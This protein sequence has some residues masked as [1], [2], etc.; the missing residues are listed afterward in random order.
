MKSPT[1]PEAPST[2]PLGI[3]NGLPLPDQL[4][5]SII[6]SEKPT[7]FGGYSDIYEGLW[8]ISGAEVPVAIKVLRNVRIMN[9]IDGLRPKEIVARVCIS[10]IY[11]ARN[12]I[13]V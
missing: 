13:F 3:R 12:P 11:T 1:L 7:M 10:L 8:E 2:L 6:L 5:G 4:E 9:P